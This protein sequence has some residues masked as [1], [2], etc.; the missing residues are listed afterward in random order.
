[1]AVSV[2]LRS[3]YYQQASSL[4]EVELVS[5]GLQRIDLS[6]WLPLFGGFACRAYREMGAEWCEFAGTSSD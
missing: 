2:F 1:M 4:G 5:T 3:S 6:W